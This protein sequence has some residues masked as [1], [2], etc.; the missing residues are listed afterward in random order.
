MN[1]SWQDE[2][3]FR[4]LIFQSLRRILERTNKPVL[5]LSGGIDSSL[6]AVALNMMGEK[7][8]PTL[9]VAYGDFETSDTLRAAR[10]AKVLFPHAPHHIIRVKRDF[11]T[12]E[13]HAKE[14]IE[15]TGCVRETTIEVSLLTWV[16]LRRTKELGY[17]AALVGCEAGA[18]WGCNRSAM[19]TKKDKG[20]IEWRSE[21]LATL[22]LTECGWPLS[23][24]MTGK[25]YAESLGLMWCDAYLDYDLIAWHLPKTYEEVNAGRG[26]KGLA[27]RSFPLLNKLKPK[28]NPMQSCAGVPR[29]AEILTKEKGYKSPR[30]FY[31]SLAKESGININGDKK[32]LEKYGT[33]TDQE[34]VKFIHGQIIHLNNLGL[35]HYFTDCLYDEN[36]RL[37]L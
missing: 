18:L 10:T 4:Y 35:T 28:R 22:H 8:I 25:L 32:H 21:R 5:F 9:T 7:E 31:N 26:E 13:R 12:L 37:I 11:E 3:L 6:L 30:A 23:A 19:Q 34:F 29:T 20:M 36:S 2:N 14:C 33:N 16:A 24:N 15:F 1:N 27:F 17:E